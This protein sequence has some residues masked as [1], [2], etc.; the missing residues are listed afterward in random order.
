M[1]R[2][3]PIALAVLIAAILAGVFI[4]F[5]APLPLVRDKPRLAVTAPPKA[6]A[7]A[8]ETARQDKTADDFLRAAQ[9]ILKRLPDTQ[10]SARTDELPIVGRIPLPKPR[11]VAPV[12][13]TR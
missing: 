10:A 8:A 2:F 13:Q 1:I 12:P 7:P 11:P 5:A 4:Y 3:Q 6:S 9:E